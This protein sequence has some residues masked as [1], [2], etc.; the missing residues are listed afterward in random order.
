M[1]SL[2]VRHDW[3]T[4]LS[5][6]LSCIGEGNGNPLQC[7]SLE[8]PRDG[9]AWWAAVCGVAQ[10]QTWL[11]QLSSSSSSSMKHPLIELSLLSHLLQMQNDCRTVNTEFFANLSCGC[12]RI[13]LSDGSQLIVVNFWWST[14]MLL[15]FKALVS[16][17]NSLNHLCTVRSLAVPGPSALLML[18]LVSATSQPTLNLNKKTTWI[19]FLSKHHFPNLK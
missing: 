6:S 15:I 5:L 10:S 3:T 14:T 9:G 8:N 18:Q 4:S 1:G 17:Q 16:L 7:S 13:R 12:K 19:C 2:G 11:K